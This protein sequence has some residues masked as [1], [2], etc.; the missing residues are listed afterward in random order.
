MT[1]LHIH[2]RRRRGRTGLALCLALVAIGGACGSDDSGDAVASTAPPTDLTGDAR[3]EANKA[4]GTITFTT[5]YGFFP[6]V[7]VFDVITADQKGYFDEMCLDVDVQPSLPGEALVLLTAD[8]IQFSANSFGSIA[9]GYEQ[10]ADIM[11]LLNYGWKPINVLI[12]PEDSPIKE[13]ADFKGTTIAT[14]NG[15]VGVPIQSMLGT[16]GLVQGEDY[17][18]LAAGYDPFVI[19]QD[20]IAGLAGYRSNNPDTLAR[21]GVT[22]RLIKPEDYGVQASFGAIVASGRFVRDHPTAAEDFI[23]A[24][25][26]GWEYAIQPAN[27]D[28]VVGFSQTLTEGDFDFDHEMYRFTTERDF[29]IDSNPEGNPYGHLLP[30]LIQTEI[31]DLVTN[32]VLE[33]EMDAAVLY[34]N[35]VIDRIYGGG[36][37][38]VWP[39]PIKD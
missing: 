18:P 20:G 30:D 17:T 8:K 31:D 36:T 3:C 16:A 9:K 21:A 26:H 15:D 27:A 1:T 13:P 2:K 5:G 19:E 23:R 33:G 6:S 11:T 39:G 24:V 35:D 12:V 10:G 4:A 32:G 37:T 29:A 38:A 7:S 25:L 28:E 34:T 14:T 22:T